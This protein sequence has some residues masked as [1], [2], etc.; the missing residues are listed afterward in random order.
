M[1]RINTIDP[2]LLSDKHLNAEYRE[3][4]RI[5]DLAKEACKRKESP[6]DKRNPS[7]YTMGTGHVRFFYNKLNWLVSRQRAIIAEKDRR[8]FVSNFTDVN[9]LI[10]GI[11][12]VWLGD[13][14]PTDRD[15]AVNLQRLI[16]RDPSFYVDVLF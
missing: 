7:K 2:E 12:K 16:T 4:P 8:G 10:D 14:Q 11:P 3:L 5:F 1:T 9:S 15:Y 6:W 13:W